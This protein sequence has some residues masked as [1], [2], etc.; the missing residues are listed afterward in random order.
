VGSDE[1]RQVADDVDPARVGVAFECRPL[2]MEAPLA[3][4]PEVDLLG[5]PLCCFAQ[6]VPLALRERRRP[7][8]PHPAVAA[9]GEVDGHE[10]RVV[11]EPG[12]RVGAESIEGGT[13]AG[14]PAAEKTLGGT[15]QMANPEASYRVVIDPL[16]GKRR[17][18]L[19]IGIAQPASVAQLAKIDQEFI[20]G[21]GR[22]ADVGRVAWSDAAERQHLPERLAGTD[23]PVD[24]VIGSRAKITRTMRTRQRSR[25]EENAVMAGKRSHAG[26]LC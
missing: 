17:Y 13:F 3:E 5:V 21:E 20:A 4:L 1:N 23:Q 15:S 24:E 7:I 18:R 12:M 25:V 22:G 16:F 26:P 10:Q 14:V 9:V 11:V 19:E 2:R 8:L 6:C